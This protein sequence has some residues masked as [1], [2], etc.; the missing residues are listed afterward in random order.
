MIEKPLAFVGKIIADFTHEINNHLALIKESA[1][2]I[3]DICKGKKSIDKKEMPYI[4][5]SIEAIENQINRSVGFINYFNRFAHRMD[6]LKS[7]FKLSSAVEELFEL[8]KRY[9]NR[10]KVTLNH[11]LSA[12]MPDIES[13]P[14]IV[15]FAIFYVIDSFLKK[16]KPDTK[17]ILTADASSNLVTV[18]IKYN[19]DFTENTTSE[20]WNISTVQE[21]ASLAN[22]KISIEDKTAT[23]EIPV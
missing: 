8:L 20:I 18:T 17:I 22:I 7:S 16:S 14:F 12:D 2:L 19:G 3:S 6:N 5:E 4:I 11:D 23:I 1:G 10:K 13:S 15:E 9:S 21:I